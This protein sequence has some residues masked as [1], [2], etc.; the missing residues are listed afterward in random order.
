VKRT[1]FALMVLAAV[2]GGQARGQDNDTAQ[3]D[4]SVALAKAH[5]KT[6]PY[7]PGMKPFHIQATV[8]SWFSIRASGSGTIDEQ[9]VDS[10]HWVRRVQLGDYQMTEMRNDT[11][12][13]WIWPAAAEPSRIAD[14]MTYLYANQPNSSQVTN[15][16]VKESTVHTADQTQNC[17]SAEPQRQRTDYPIHYGWCFDASTGLPVSEDLP[18]D[19]HVIFDYTAF[20]GKQ[21]P[22]KIK[23]TAGG[24]AIVDIQAS[25]STLD[26][27]V[28]D[29]LAPTRAMSRLVHNSVHHLN[30]EELKSGVQVRHPSPLLPEGTP[31]Q[32]AKKAAQ[33]FIEIDPTGSPVDAEIESA[34]DEAMAVAALQ[35]TQKWL[36]KPFL[37]DGKP[38]TVRFPMTV[39]FIK[40]PAKP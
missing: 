40:Q 15:L 10:T 6:H 31:A 28:L 17:F 2:L 12:D 1:T 27:H 36:Y 34:P 21:L 11:G 3:E 32:D 7:V 29:T 26:P 39:E 35:I 5:A 20:Q 30:P 9:W 33:V 18:L 19:I 14:I 37:I 24:L 25:Y 16:L 23:A 38:A 13:P 4:L 8:A 22:T